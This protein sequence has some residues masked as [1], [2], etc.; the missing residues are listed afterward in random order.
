MWNRGRFLIVR[1]SVA[2]F[3][4]LLVYQPARADVTAWLTDLEAAKARAQKE[5]KHV[6]V[7]FTGSDWCVWCKRLSSEVFR[8]EA[9]QSEALKHYILVELDFPA[10]NSL[11][12][13][14]TARNKKLAE[15]FKIAGFPTVLLL[16]AD[17]RE[18][19]RTGY[20]AGG[21]ETYL[22]Q[23]AALEKIYVTLSP[24]K[25]LLAKASGLD[26]AKLLD[27]IIDAYVE[28]NVQSEE[29]AALSREIVSLDP[30]NQYGL[31]NKHDYLLLANAAKNYF[32]EKKYDEAAAA[33]DK[34]LAISGLTDKQKFAAYEIKA[35]CADARQEYPVAIELLEKAIALDP[36]NQDAPFVKLSLN[37]IRAMLKAEEGLKKAE[38][39]LDKTE[40]LERAKALDRLITAKETFCNY[41]HLPG[42]NK[43]VAEHCLEILALDPDNK[44]GLKTKVETRLL[45]IQA[46]SLF[47][48]GKYA[49]AQAAFA[50][51]LQSPSLPAEQIQQ[52][53][54][55]QG[56]CYSMLKEPEKS[57]DC[58]QKALRAAPESD[59]ALLLKTIL[60]R[61]KKR[62][63]RSDSGNEP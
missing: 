44:T 53:F 61:E 28:L 33:S 9:F 50:F 16:N 29:S 36:N 55:A 43:E 20:R 6:L 2:L 27:K 18:I 48:T 12:E 31:K 35:W 17:G 47:V 11:P 14:L 10:Q 23:M 5:N 60:K 26:R 22:L 63:N 13:E 42:G 56:V 39:D 19:A 7:F 58:Y 52:A 15:Q 57:L 54:Y 30:D 51:Y 4:F 25:G 32:Q 46:S 59:N 37:N 41:R 40:G 1:A 24:M 3:F 38:A 45:L 21:P 8:K 34:A 62:R 49:E